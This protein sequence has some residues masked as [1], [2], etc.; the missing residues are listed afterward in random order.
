MHAKQAAIIAATV[1]VATLI[2]GSI[3][4]QTQA[5][6]ATYQKAHS[7]QGHTLTE[8]RGAA[9]GHIKIDF[10][11]RP[12]PLPPKMPPV[13]SKADFTIEASGYARNIKDRS[14]VDA[15]LALNGS[16]NS[17][18]SRGVLHIIGGYL[19]A[20]D[21]QYTISSGRGVFN[22]QARGIINMQLRT[23]D[24]RTIIL[25]GII[26]ASSSTDG[27]EIVF[28]SILNTGIQARILILEGSLQTTEPITAYTIKTL[29]GTW[30][31]TTIT[32]RIENGSLLTPEYRG[33]INRAIDQWNS[34]IA[35]FAGEYSDYSYL[36]KVKLELTDSED[37]DVKILLTDRLTR[38]IGGE[39]DASFKDGTN[40]FKNITV[41]LNIGPRYTDQVVYAV[42]LH[43]LG[44]A[45][46]LAHTNIPQDIMYPLLKQWGLRKPAIST[47][48]LYAI[49]QVFG[50]LPSDSPD[51]YTVP[52]EVS[53]PRGIEYK[54]AP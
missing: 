12:A 24:S 32:V 5:E 4:L 9:L 19:T 26:A 44:H 52:K 49:A 10:F 6:A 42:A 33:A 50:W 48:D 18:G 15:A 30:D 29:N 11:P 51:D 39:T 22:T 28:V 20:G 37:A 8:S 46:G 54:F 25:H 35:W 14:E 2:L 36:S 27:Y 3:A 23:D 53:L 31:H 7:S 13:L 34:A 38:R 1:L 16:I 41:Y 40:I 43:E 21:E 47:L 45:L 17:I